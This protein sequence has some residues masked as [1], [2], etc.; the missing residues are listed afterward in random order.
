MR[1]SRIRRFKTS[2]EIT[3]IVAKE[4]VT[5]LSHA[6]FCHFNQYKCQFPKLEKAGDKLLF[7]LFRDGIDAL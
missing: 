5:A 2:K 4:D 3:L 7:K 6:I 1:V